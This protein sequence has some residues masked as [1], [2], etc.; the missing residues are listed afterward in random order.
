MIVSYYL[1]I[2]DL[3]VLLIPIVITL[4]RF[5]F[6]P[7]ETRATDAG[8]RRSLDVGRIAGGAYVYIPDSRAFLPGVAALCALYGHPDS[9]FPPRATTARFRE[10]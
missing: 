2:H 1:F 10:T 7:A 4:D 3:S 8:R 5:I 6:S 9:K